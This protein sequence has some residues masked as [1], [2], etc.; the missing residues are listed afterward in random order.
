MQTL[1]QVFQI[2]NKH[3]KSISYIY[4]KYCPAL[5]TIGLSTVTDLILIQLELEVESFQIVYY[6]QMHLTVCRTIM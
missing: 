2:P 4:F 3:T 6:R 1:F 5:L